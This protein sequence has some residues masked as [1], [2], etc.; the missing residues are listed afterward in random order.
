MRAIV[1]VLICVSVS[2][3]SL[4]RP[5]N[6][7]HSALPE[8]KNWYRQGDL[9]SAESVLLQLQRKQQGSAESDFLLA[10]IYFRQQRLAA[11][12]KQYERVLAQQSN[13]QRA[14]HNLALTQLRLTT[15]T[16][17]R[18]RVA[19]MQLPEADQQLLQ[20]L[21]KLQRIPSQTKSQAPITEHQ[22]DYAF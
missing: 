14:W 18:A 20:V 12:K 13:H 21:L 10:N 17:M 4:A 22:S 5:I 15:D 7:D 2:S 19:L 3:C 6:I 8:A 11:A 9:D 1:A 16:L